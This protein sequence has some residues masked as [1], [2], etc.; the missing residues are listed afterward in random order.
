MIFPSTRES[1]D[2]LNRLRTSGADG[3][4]SRRR[5]VFRGSLA[6]LAV[7]VA[8][9][10]LARP[11]G[12]TAAPMTLLRFQSLAFGTRV[13]ITV[14][15]RAT[16]VASTTRATR[17]AH[18]ALAEVAAIDALTNLQW[19]GS[20]LSTLNR[21]G[22][23]RRPDSR[24]VTLMTI[25]RNWG[26]LSAGAFDVT[27]QPLWRLYAAH[28][29]VGSIPNSAELTRA[30]A[31]VDYR[32]LQVS[33]GRITLTR[34]QAA[35]T[36]NGIVQGFAADRAL[37][38]LRAHGIQDALVDAG[39]LVGSGHRPGGELWQIAVRQPSLNAARDPLS[40]R[41]GLDDAAIATSAD[42]GC[43]F[44]ADRRHHHIMNPR[45][46]RSP[47][48]LAGAT[49]IAP[50]AMTA[51]A[52]STAALVMGS[53][54]CLDLLSSKPSVHALLTTKQGEQIRSPDWP[55]RLMG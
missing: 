55:V 17:A 5:S 38:T 9:G 51:D 7:G 41:I 27:V 10:V 44:S 30:L 24:L 14:G 37:A 36:L 29:A 42:A 18:A 35:V 45:D 33:D 31:L 1:P 52:L 8:R 16:R 48:E 40:D 47:T 50:E 2:Q 39:E 28:A 3:S 32:G 53:R 34:P 54:R 25:A 15:E 43:P 19:S 4:S 21:T 46:G 11:V 20:A 26:D 12:S 22:E 23:L 49:V 13:S 6:L